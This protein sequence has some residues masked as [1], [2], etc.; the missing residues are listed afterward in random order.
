MAADPD[1]DMTRCC[2]YHDLSS[3]THTD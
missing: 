3:R 2:S 1:R